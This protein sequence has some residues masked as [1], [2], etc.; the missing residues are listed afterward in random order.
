MTPYPGTTRDFIKEHVVL[1]GYVFHLVDTAGLGDSDDPVESIGIDKS[2]R[3]AGEADG[4]VLVIDGSRKFS[5]EDRAL[6]ERLSDRKIVVV[7]NKIDLSKRTGT[8]AVAEV[9]PGRPVVEVSALN[10]TNMEALRSELVDSFA[11]REDPGRD[12]IMHARQRDILAGI[13]EALSKAREL[14]VSG[15][16][17]ELCAEEI[18]LALRLMGTLTGEIRSEDVMNDIFGRF[19]VGK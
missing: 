13:R 2:W 10:G 1:G 12:V 19:C 16:P 3:I 4:L 18:R 7:L 8:A 5:E 11:P 17:D 9:L 15:Y 6:V 14:I